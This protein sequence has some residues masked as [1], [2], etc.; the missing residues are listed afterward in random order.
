MLCGRS[1]TCIEKDWL[2][3]ASQR[4]VDEAEKASL[5]CRD[6]DGVGLAVD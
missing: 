6:G 4:W 5:G 3:K 1:L 2:E